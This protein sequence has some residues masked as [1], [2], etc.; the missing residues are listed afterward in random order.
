MKLPEHSGTIWVVGMS[1]EQALS[2]ASPK[3]VMSSLPAILH[4]KLPLPSSPPKACSGPVPQREA[5]KGS[6]LPPHEAFNTVNCFS[7]LL[8]RVGGFNDAERVAACL[9]KASV[10]TRDMLL[11]AMQ[12]LACRLWISALLCS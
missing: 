2:S 6:S 8:W 4:C 11:A 1:D 12:Q 5:D 3:L 9:F 7:L 10:A